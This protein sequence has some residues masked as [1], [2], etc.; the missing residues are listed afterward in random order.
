MK[1]SKINKPDKKKSASKYSICQMLYLKSQ[2]IT[3]A[4]AKALSAW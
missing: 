2:L 3:L 4:S 1:T